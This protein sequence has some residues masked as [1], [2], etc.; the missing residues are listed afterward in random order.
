ML[1]DPFVGVEVG[2]IGRQALDPELL[3]IDLNHQAQM[4]QELLLSSHRA[5][6]R[7]MVTGQIRSQNLRSCTWGVATDRTGSQVQAR[8]V[9]EDKG[10]PADVD[11]ELFARAKVMGMVRT[12]IGIETDAPAGLISLRRGV[13]QEQS[14]RACATRSLPSMCTHARTCS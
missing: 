5:D 11:G 8:F 2:R 4:S 14:Q 3:G 10:Q 9:D 1:P 6:D 7:Q 12:Y 13:T